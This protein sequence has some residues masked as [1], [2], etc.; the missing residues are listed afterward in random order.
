MLRLLLPIS[1]LALFG[2]CVDPGK[3]KSAGI[4]INEPIR[5]QIK[6][7]ELVVATSRKGKEKVGEIS[8]MDITEQFDKIEI[9]VKPKDNVKRVIA[10]DKA[11]RAPTIFLKCADNVELE[12]KLDR[13]IFRFSTTLDTM[14]EDLG[15]GA[16]MRK[17]IEW[18][19]HHKNDASIKPIYEEIALD[20]PTGKDAEASA[21]NA[22]TGEVSEAPASNF[23]PKELA[24]DNEKRLVFPIWDMKFLD[25]KWP[26]LVD[27]ILAANYLNIKLLLTFATTMVDNKWIKAKTPQEIRKTFRVK[28]EFPP[29][30]PEWDRVAKENEWDESEGEREARQR[31]VRKRKNRRVRKRKQSSFR[32]EQLQQQNQKHQPHPGQQHD[33]DMND[34]V[35]DDQ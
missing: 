21:S 15:I 23:K 34:D 5:N 7:K 29:G 8:I 1:I 22:Q 3:R 11:K 31:S 13:N 4:S 12:V 19:E 30:D 9:N 28:E 18:C 35:E 33:E 17:V 32:Q 14:M 2:D 10:Q 6:E 26:E 16:V 24:A 20:V 25:K 27:I